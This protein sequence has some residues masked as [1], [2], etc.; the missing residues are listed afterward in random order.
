MLLLPYSSPSLV[1]ATQPDPVFS[2][3]I[4]VPALSVAGNTPSCSCQSFAVPRSPNGIQAMSPTL[5]S[6]APVQDTARVPA[7]HQPRL[8]LADPLHTSPAGPGSWTMPW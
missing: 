7:I 6:V 8:A 5:Q 4:V 1:Y 3:A 2:T